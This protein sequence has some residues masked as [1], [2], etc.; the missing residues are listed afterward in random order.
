MSGKDSSKS[1]AAFENL[2]L[3]ESQSYIYYFL[4]DH[5]FSSLT[6]ACQFF[7]QRYND[8]FFIFWRAFCVYKSGIPNQA[9]NEIAK[10]SNMQEIQWSCAKAS[11]FYHKKCDP[12]DYRTVDQLEMMEADYE[13][14]ARERDIVAG[15]YFL[16]LLSKE[17]GGDVEWAKDILGRSRFDGPLIETCRG[18]CEIY[19]G[20][21]GSLVRI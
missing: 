13:R 11:I 4:H 17:E 14:T 5:H 20:E 2:N 3:Q 18:W 7:Y 12:I 19:Q 6:A 21:S 10:V 16:M 15:C 9:V 8:P 1:S